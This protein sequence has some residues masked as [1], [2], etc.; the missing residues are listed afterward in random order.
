MVLTSK[1]VMLK[2]PTAYCFCAQLRSRTSI[3]PCMEAE[4]PK[5]A[6]GWNTLSVALIAE[7]LKDHGQL[8]VDHG[9]QLTGY[10][11]WPASFPPNS[12]EVES[13]TDLT[14]PAKVY[15]PA[16]EILA[17]DDRFV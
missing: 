6:F 13:V 2:G 8:L 10:L 12:L 1:A 4:N 7:R 9:G 11:S 16:L 17:L 3:C 14:C 15:R 5:R